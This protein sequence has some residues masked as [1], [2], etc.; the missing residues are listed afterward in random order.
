MYN[1]CV[2]SCMCYNIPLLSLGQP[3]VFTLNFKAA[4][5]FPLDIYFLLDLTGSFSQR[6][7]DTVTPLAAD[8]CMYDV[9]VCNKYNLCACLCI[10]QARISGL[11]CLYIK[12]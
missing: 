8:L 1:V 5:N 4:E 7:R 10:S 11:S 2:W 3:E 9:F 6:F 12:G